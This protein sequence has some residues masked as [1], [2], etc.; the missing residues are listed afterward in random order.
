MLTFFHIF[1]HGDVVNAQ[2][3]EVSPPEK[4]SRTTLSPCFICSCS[5]IILKKHFFST[6]RLKPFPRILSPLHPILYPR[7]IYSREILVLN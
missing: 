2:T 4:S 5:P 7:T 1:I 6:V 3:W